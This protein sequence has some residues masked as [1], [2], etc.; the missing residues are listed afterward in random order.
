MNTRT[1]SDCRT[2]AAGNIVIRESA[3]VPAAWGST[4]VAAIATDPSSAQARCQA[5]NSK[6]L[7]SDFAGALSDYQAAAATAET[8]YGRD[9]LLTA[10]C[11]AF[12]G[13]V[14]QILGRY[15]EALAMNRE[16]LRIR[17][18]FMPPGAVEIAHSCNNVATALEH[19]GRYRE[20]ERYYS[21]A[22]QIE[23]AAFGRSGDATLETRLNQAGTLYRASRLHETAKLITGIV[24]DVARRHSVGEI[25]NQVLAVSALVMLDRVYR[26]TGRRTF[27]ARHE[28]L[29]REYWLA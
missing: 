26:A 16:V 12:V 1:T 29:L 25:T 9:H 2:D 18:A 24:D 11:L 13:I 27:K 22:I 19:L 20:T 5:G 17:E 14:L 8:T 21:R 15:E 3:C 6:Y 7:R 28:A 10:N 23:T 4:V